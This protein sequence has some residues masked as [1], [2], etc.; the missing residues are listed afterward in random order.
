M[1]KFL[2][3]TG[4]AALTVVVAAAAV[5][6]L[7]AFQPLRTRWTNKWIFANPKSVRDAFLVLFH[8]KGN[9]TYSEMRWFGSHILKTPMDLLIYQEILNELKPDVVVETGTYKGGSALFLSHMM[10]LI[11]KGRVITIDIE[12]HPEVPKHDRIKYL[13]GSSTDPAIVQQVKDSI[14][15]GETVMVLLDS[16]HSMKHVLNEIH[17]YHDLVTPGS[18]LVVEDTHLSGHPVLPK[19]GP[20]PREAADQFLAE[21]KNFEVDS[22]R[23][24]LIITFNPRGYLRRVQ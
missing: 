16:D 14:R 7:D 4:I 12:A 15:P 10:D 18:Y 22:A 3:W 21:N 5:I 11:G 8:E 24:K 2:R 19:M 13:V 17:A 20:G 1:D 9:S 23:E 6:G